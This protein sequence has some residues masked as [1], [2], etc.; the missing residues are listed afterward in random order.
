MAI[1]MSEYFGRNTWQRRVSQFSLRWISIALSVLPCLISQRAAFNNHEATKLKKQIHQRANQKQMR[2]QRHQH[3]PLTRFYSTEIPVLITFSWSALDADSNEHIVIASKLILSPVMK[4]E[5]VR[6]L[7][8]VSPRSR[9]CGHPLASHSTQGIFIRLKFQF[10]WHH[11]V[12][13]LTLIPMNTLLS[14]A[15]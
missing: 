8:P 10:W 15:N 1:S 11:L 4:L 14:S 5:R 6:Q 13:L 12:E 7:W 3:R 2:H 9:L